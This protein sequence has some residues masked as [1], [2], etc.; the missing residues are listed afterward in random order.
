MSKTETLTRSSLKPHLAKSRVPFQS[1]RVEQRA[2]AE[3][4]KRKR[5]GRGE[6]PEERT[7]LAQTSTSKVVALA[8]KVA[9]KDPTRR[10]T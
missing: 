6:E 1:L 8:E 10:A 7:P 5:V 3:G 9:Q 2:T 4:T